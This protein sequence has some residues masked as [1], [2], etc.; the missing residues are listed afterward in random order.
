MPTKTHLRCGGGLC[1]ASQEQMQNK[2]TKDEDKLKYPMRVPS[3]FE[4]K[5]RKVVLSIA[6]KSAAIAKKQC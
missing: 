3:G 6:Q 1:T 5:V 4:L 2:E